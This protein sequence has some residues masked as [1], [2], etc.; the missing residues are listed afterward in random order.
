MKSQ[1]E[2]MVA[3]EKSHDDICNVQVRGSLYKAIN[4]ALQHSLEYAP[5]LIFKKFHTSTRDGGDVGTIRS[6]TTDNERTQPVL[7][8]AIKSM[9]MSTMSSKG[10]TLGSSLNR[11]QST[12]QAITNFDVV[13][14]NLKMPCLSMKVH[15]RKADF[16]GRQDI[17]DLIDK[18][19]L[20]EN[21]R[22]VTFSEGFL[23]SFALCGMGGIG[24][25]QIAVEYAYSR[26]SKYDAIF[27]ITADG[28]TVLSE[29]FAR[30]A[31]QLGLEDQSEANDITVSREIPEN[32]ASWLLIFDNV[33][34]LDVLDDFWPT[35][36]SGAVLLTSR[37]SLAKNQ[38]H[39]ANNGIDLQ[40]F[41]AEDAIQFLKTLS[42]GPLQP[43]QEKYAAELADRLG[44]LPLLITQMAGVMARLR[45]SYS[46][47]IELYNASGIEQISMTGSNMSTPQ[48]VYWISY[49]LGFDGLAPTSF[50]LLSLIAML[51]PNRIPEFILTD[52]CSKDSKISL[53]HF[54]KTLQQYYEARAQLLQTSLINQNSETG[55]VWVHRIVQDVT[56]GKLIQHRLV[57][58]YNLAVYAEL[59]TATL[60]SDA[61]WYRFER[62][63]QEE[64]KEWFE[65]V[66]EICDGLEDKSSEDVKYMIR[67]THHHL[68]TASGET[69]D[70]GRFLKH[71]GIWPE[72]LLERKTP[73]GELVVDYELGM[74]Y[75]EH[76]NSQAMH[77][78]ANK[79]LIHWILGDYEAAEHTFIDIIVVFR[80]ANGVDDILSF[81]TGKMLYGLGNVYVSQGK[82]EKGLKY[83]IRCLKQYRAT[84]GDRHH[85]IG[86]ICHRLADDNLRFKNYAEAYAH[87]PSPKELAR[88]TYKASQV[89]FGSVNTSKAESELRDAFHFL[90]AL[91]PDDD[92]GMDELTEEDYD[93]LVV[94]WSR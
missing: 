1:H 60:F 56:N 29:E 34:D 86:D 61:G 44:G 57:D 51:N 45:L 16:F 5:G 65:L 53:E 7:I 40:P 49:K 59:A 58:I 74:G 91:V 38:I 50:G 31:V 72:M 84:L 90:Q 46:E 82:F 48:R 23:R 17:L 66:Q 87:Q 3:T 85:R 92:R 15:K 73:D 35:T 64:S 21:R 8:P 94:F 2:I 14:K 20:L 6:L 41:S 28:K 27:F 12:D 68:G 11:S 43:T 19:L 36:G 13:N 9:E 39:T 93:N 83:Y 71:S 81:K 76:G 54:P 62:G 89:S 32:E 18:N 63:F 47:F 77:S 42:R 33:D 70:T 69:N 22:N 75:N 78:T 4:Y 88:S 37:D 10:A 67:D 26:M 55:D 25:T 52:A 24:K 79:G 30:I 80:R